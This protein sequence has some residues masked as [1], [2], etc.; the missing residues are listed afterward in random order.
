MPNEKKVKKLLEKEGHAVFHEF[1]ATRTKELETAMQASIEKIKNTY[2]SRQQYLEGL[3]NFFYL[4]QNLNY[5]IESYDKG[6]ELV[7]A[8]FLGFIIDKKKTN[9]Y[10]PSAIRLRFAIASSNK[11]IAIPA[12]YSKDITAIKGASVGMSDDG[13]EKTLSTWEAAIKE[14]NVDRKI[15][16]VITG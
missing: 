15:R 3:F 14:S 2:A 16:H 11:Y 7:P 13:L 8:V 6:Q 12:S 4:G 9:P 10:T 1:V 5:P